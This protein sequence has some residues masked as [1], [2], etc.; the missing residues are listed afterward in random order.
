MRVVKTRTTF[1]KQLN[2]FPI[3]GQMRLNAKLLNWIWNNKSWCFVHFS[4]RTNSKYKLIMF[5]VLFWSCTPSQ[6]NVI[7]NLLV[8]I[9]WKVL[10]LCM[11]IRG[12]MLFICVYRLNNE[13]LPMFS[14]RWATYCLDCVAVEMSENDG[15]LVLK[16]N[17]NSIIIMA[18]KIWWAREW[19]HALKCTWEFVSRTM[20]I[21]RAQQNAMNANIQPKT[22]GCE[23]LCMC[24]RHTHTHKFTHSYTHC[25][26][27]HLALLVQ[28]K[29]VFLL[30][31]GYQLR[32]FTNPCEVAIQ[33]AAN[34]NPGS[35]YST[36]NK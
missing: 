24:V 23:M 12:K 22:A 35:S 30:L 16:F 11:C 28:G 2:A 13:R 27:I 15:N 9:S 7:P 1:S 29:L 25:Y 20:R 32:A 8:E 4:H 5:I 34:I 19:E 26:M 36:P 21:P 17:S 14:L 6:R 18:L 33:L 10:S 3:E 31:F